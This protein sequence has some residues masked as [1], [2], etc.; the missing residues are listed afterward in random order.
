MAFDYPIVILSYGGRTHVASHGND[1]II[2]NL[3]KFSDL[4]YYPE[5]E[6]MMAFSVQDGFS[7]MVPVVFT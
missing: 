1:A 4:N 3:L 2:I 6:D 5:S 7:S